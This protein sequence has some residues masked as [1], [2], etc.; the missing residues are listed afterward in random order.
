MVVSQFSGHD[1]DPGYMPCEITVGSCVHICDVGTLTLK[2]KVC[3]LLFFVFSLSSSFALFW[4][5][6]VVT[7][8]RSVLSSLNCLIHSLISQLSISLLGYC[9]SFAKTLS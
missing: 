3:S 2:V 7:R 5:F 8:Y 1:P 6:P 4:C 9:H